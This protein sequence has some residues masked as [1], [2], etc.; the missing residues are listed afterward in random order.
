M[1]S[2]T[3]K[4]TTRGASKS[5]KNNAK[6]KAPDAK[7]APKKKPPRMKHEKG[8]EE[9]KLATAVKLYTFWKKS[10]GLKGP[11]SR[12]SDMV[13]YVDNVASTEVR[14]GWCFTTA[15]SLCL[16]WTRRSEGSRGGGGSTRM[17]ARR[18]SCRWG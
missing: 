10:E 13:T 14:G 2:T 12:A 18:A 1:R 4:T 3:Q 8:T 11:V 9:C 5:M 15:A 16:R 17:G 6:K 7:K